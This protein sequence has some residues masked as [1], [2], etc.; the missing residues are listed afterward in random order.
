MA[1]AGGGARAAISADGRFVAFATTA[2]LSP[3]DGS[4]DSDVYV[5]DLVA[6]TTTLVSRAPGL[7][8]AKG[9]GRSVDPAISADG[10]HVA[11]ASESTN[12]STL[13]A[14]AGLDVYVRDLLTGGTILASRASGSRSGVK[15]NGASERPAISADLR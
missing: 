15:G 6:Q 8:G 7:A 9:N 10:R 5:R 11:F 3:V 1:Q 12:L 4:P 13:D 14:E 2:S